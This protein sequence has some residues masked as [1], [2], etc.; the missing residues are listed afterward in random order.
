VRSPIFVR[1][2]PVY[3]GNNQFRLYFPVEIQY[4]FLQFVL[5]D[6][7]YQAGAELEIV[8]KK[9]GTDGI[10]N[11]I[12]K[13]QT[14]TTTFDSTNRRDVYHFTI[15]SLSVSAGKYEILL[16]YRDINGGQRYAARLKIRLPEVKNRY[17][18]PPL[19]L[20]PG[21]TVKPSFRGITFQPSALREYWNFNQDVKLYLNVWDPSLSEEP[22]TSIRIISQKLA[23]KNKLNAEVRLAR[24]G[25][26]VSGV[27]ELSS[28]LLPEGI[29]KLRIV[30][31]FASDSVVQEMPFKVV[32]FEK[33]RSLRNFNLAI[34]VMKYILDEE[35]YKKLNKGNSKEKQQKFWSY[36]K[37]QD[38]TPETP[39]NELLTEFYTRVD[40]A[41][42]RWSSRRI[43]GWKTDVGR[44]Y[45]LYG[46]PDEVEDRSLD[47]IP[48]PYMKW[49]YKR[50]GKR[51]IFTFR[52]IEGRK[53]FEL[54]D[55]REES[56]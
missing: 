20:Y 2:Y 30:Y 46:P 7:T 38:P 34:A 4:D 19:F 3:L 51:L 15:D 55:T 52:S 29:H 5:R 11:V 48:N 23:V 47:P 32:W 17:V 24:N 12:W 6:G 39:Y 54:V 1:D 22:M 33:P 16:K 37:Q 31:H 49:I 45:I 28:H 13:T 8:L 42:V 36:W 9:E 10:Q 43:P 35:E 53:R 21:R 14:H 26:W 50:D 56:L 40:S 25:N 18:S 27:A 41:N 44:I